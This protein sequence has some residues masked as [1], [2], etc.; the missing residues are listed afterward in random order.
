[1]RPLLIAVLL[2]MPS[3]CSA[4]Y[5]VGGQTV[6]ALNEFESGKI[7]EGFGRLSHAAL[8]NNNI[9]AQYFLAVCYEKG[10]GTDIN[11]EIAFNLYRKCAERGLPESMF[12][13]S[14]CYKYGIGVAISI[15]KSEEWIKRFNNKGGQISL[16]D[17]STA[18]YQG[19]KVK[20]KCNDKSIEYTDGPSSD[21]LSA[22]NETINSTVYQSEVNNGVVS[23]IKLKSK[24]DQSI[25]STD[26]TNKNTFALIIANENYLEVAKVPYAL[27][28][29]DIFAEYCMK[30]L[31]IPEINVHLVKDGT[32]NQMKREIKLM[33]DIAQEVGSEMKL[34]FY[35]AGH[36]IPDDSSREAFLMPVDGYGSDLTTCY[37]LNSLYETLGGIG[38][39]KIIV[40][41][42]ACFSGDK[43]DDG[44][45]YSTRG[46]AIRPR[47]SEPKGN[48][49]VISATQGDERA[50]S[51]DEE[52]HGLF[53]YF[54][55]KNLYDNRGETRIKDVWQYLRNNVR[56]QSLI[57]YGK[58]QTPTIQIS[59]DLN[60]DWEEWTLW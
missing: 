59:R 16:P 21:I 47:P 9:Y 36:G 17:I 34:I 50:S 8:I 32:F 29:A 44:P 2:L 24:V 6:L 12:K 10:F 52:K 40:L 39:S 51:F 18:F 45:L 22:H 60:G 27:N 25:P 7:E 37:S 55:L 13:L 54:L 20:N 38:L 4:F 56:K 46:V 19:L 35:Y 48:M 53:T 31:G 57:L 43:R 58:S 42:D 3:I 15:S 1:M 23:E 11:T 5:D 26:R 14:Q 41:L 49:V 30:T 33:G 28:D